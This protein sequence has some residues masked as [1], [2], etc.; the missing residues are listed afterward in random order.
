MTRAR[1]LIFLLA[2]VACSS[3]VGPSE[4]AAGGTTAAAPREEQVLSAPAAS[5]TS[6]GSRVF[7]QLRTRD[8]RVTL[9]T[10][11]GGL[12]VTVQNE[13]GVVV[14]EDISMDDLR[15]RDPS[16]YEL[17]RS[18]VASNHYLDARL[19]I[20]LRPRGGRETSSGPAMR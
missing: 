4:T 9:L 11:P 5:Q 18:S 2:L 1:G 12:H 17:C 19:D 10:G 14:A 7:G 16:L 8:Q 3:S 6:D 15:Q 20:P 13:S